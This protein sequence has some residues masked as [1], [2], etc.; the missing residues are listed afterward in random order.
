MRNRIYLNR[1]WN[2]VDRFED[3]FKANLIQDGDTVTIPHTV[4]VTPY[5]Y[6]DEQVYQKLSTYQKMLFADPE[7]E[8]KRVILTFEGA[9]HQAE[10][11]VNGVSVA[12]HESGYT[13]FSVEVDSMLRFGEDNLVTV[14]L[15]SRETLNQPP[16]G[17]VI[18]YMTYGG[19]YRDV[20]VE[21]R[22]QESIDDV[23]FK[24]HL[25][26]DGRKV[27]ETEVNS[28]RSAEKNTPCKATLASDIQISAGLKDILIKNEASDEKRKVEIALYLDEQELTRR[29]IALSDLHG[30]KSLD[31]FLA[32]LKSEEVITLEAETEV[33]PW[34][35]ENPVLYQARVCLFVDG[36]ERDSYSSKIGFRNIE[37]RADGFYLNGKKF[38]IRGLNR[39]QSYA[40]VGYAMPES[41]QRYDAQILKNE[42]GVNAVRTSHY[43][44]SHY[45]IEECDRLGLLVFTE[46]PG[47]QHIGGREW[48]DIAVG[49]VVEMVTQY[50]NHPSIMIWG[51]RINESVDNDEFYAR[52]NAVAHIFDNTRQTGGVRC[53]TADKNTNILEDVFTYNDFVHSGDNEGCLKKEK[54][55]NDMSKGYLVTE[56]NGHMYPTKSFDWEEHR[57]NHVLRHAN[58]L[59]AIASEN[60]IAGSFGWCMFD[61]NTHK[62]F[63]SGDRICY[64]GVMDM[65]RNP[66]TASYVYAAENSE[67]TV[68]ELTSS[69][70]IGEHPASNRGDCYIITNADSV[71]MYKNGRLLKEYFPTDSKY[72]ALKHGPI[73]IDD[74]IGNDLVTEEGMGQ[75]QAAIC[76]HLLNSYSLFN[77]KMTK[78]MVWDA[79][80]LVLVYHMNPNDAVPLYQKYIGNWGEESTEY[81]FDAI[82]GGKVVKS[83][84]VTP[85]TEAHLEVTLSQDSLQETETYDVMEMR[86]RVVDENENLLPFYNEPLTV[87]VDGPAEVIG[88]KVQCLR[89]GMTGVYLKST[90]ETGKIRITL[91]T[92]HTSPKVFM[93]EAK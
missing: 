52:T 6:F 4:E 79:I 72:K 84:V 14:K 46:I 22:E 8:G 61:Y 50:R 74:Y 70:D 5:D 43:P 15:D 65:F 40:Y 24:P 76:K 81:R 32:G 29:E 35:T 75:K 64:H 31:D 25:N 9:A 27:S 47:W 42:L 68:L 57:R 86:I 93:I 67:E 17:Y 85:M 37:F 41:M 21:I 63:G 56:Y 62:D 36:E 33:E 66:K 10:V 30:E 2:Y 28:Q 60:D 39:H 82:V 58:V 69:M 16:F 87:T 38:R 18:D 49:N 91:Q 7:W 55:T 71:K 51:V 11:F 44:Q 54:A 34:D 19:I 59:N 90:G 78:A 88:P 89:G 77:G 83:R 3:D 26:L 12:T 13:A 80:R 73:L 92:E 48:Q 53:R 1:G 23:F 45:F 20:Y